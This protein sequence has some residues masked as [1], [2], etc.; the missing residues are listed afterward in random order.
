MHVN[1]SLKNGVYH[2]TYR[3]NWDSTP[4]QTYKR[5][6]RKIAQ[7][8]VIGC[9]HANESISF[10]TDDDEETTTQHLKFASLLHP[11]NK[12]VRRPKTSAQKV[13]D[14][15]ET[16]AQVRRDNLTGTNQLTAAIESITGAMPVSGINHDL[17]EII[18]IK[19]EI[20]NIISS[21]SYIMNFLKK[22]K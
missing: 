2:K 5:C 8:E 7:K 4:H 12:L 16:I 10:M 6:E 19:S 22:H 13:K 20:S 15:S 11:D 1:L 17:S 21:L 3:I 9:V 18:D 14:L